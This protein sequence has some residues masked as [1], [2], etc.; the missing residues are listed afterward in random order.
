MADSHWTDHHA[1]AITA[2]LAALGA[3]PLGLV[4]DLAVRVITSALVGVLIALF[5][6][7]ALPRLDRWLKPPPTTPPAGD[8]P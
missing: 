2:T 1:T 3:S 5:T 6:R 8:R 4:E 7:Y